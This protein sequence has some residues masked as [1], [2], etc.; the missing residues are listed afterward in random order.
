MLRRQMVHLIAAY[1]MHAAQQIGKES[2]D[3]RVIEAMGK[4]PRQEFVPFE[5][6]PYA[7]FDGP[8]PIGYDKTI[9]QPFIAALMTDLLDAETGHRVLEVGTGLGYHAAV[10]T[11]LGAKVYSVE[12]VEELGEQAV[13]NLTRIGYK[14]IKTRIGDGS[15][16]W[17]EHAPF[18]R[19]LVCAAPELI[20][21]GLINQL[22]PGGKMVVPAGVAG[23][24]QLMLVEKD[25]SGRV[26][27][28]EVLAVNFSPLE[29]SH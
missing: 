18:D 24:Q 6:R 23:A 5:L 28:R 14:G 13:E 2:L 7:Y 9:S 17:M 1:A 29:V 12:I 27:S 10:L 11:E 15:R 20:P 3:A 4:V 8:L 26:S 22:K 25:E 19:I 21:P 16:G